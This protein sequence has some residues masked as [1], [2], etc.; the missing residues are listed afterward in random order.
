MDDSKELALFNE[1]H[2]KLIEALCDFEIV[3]DDLSDAASRLKAVKQRSDDSADILELGMAGERIQSSLERLREFM[4]IN[5]DFYASLNAV[6][7]TF[8]RK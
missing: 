2:A 7:E 8:S 3:R 6:L 4:D 5:A 1:R